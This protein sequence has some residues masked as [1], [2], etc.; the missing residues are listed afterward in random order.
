MYKPKKAVA[1]V[2]AA[3]ILLSPTGALGASPKDFSDFPNDWST[4]AMTKA[5]DNGLLG[6]VGDGL[7]APQGVLTRAQMAAIINR[8]FASS[9]KASLAGYSDVSTDAWYYDDMAKAVQMGTFS[10]SGAGLLEPER[11]I[12]REEAFS[13]LA[14]A[15]A[16]KNGDAAVLAE[17]NDGAMCL[18]GP[19]ARLRQWSVAAMSTVP[20]ASV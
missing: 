3:A 16:L 12:T 1:A 13:V 10:G 18:I 8:A 20:T 15:F 5:L 17:Y 7:S 9:D 19:K 4:S 11:P 2:C 6:G 14:R